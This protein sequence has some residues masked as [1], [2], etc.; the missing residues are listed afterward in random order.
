M[1][2]KTFIDLRKNL[3]LVA[4]KERVYRSCEHTSCHSCTL[5]FSV[6]RVLQQHLSDSTAGRFTS[7]NAAVHTWRPATTHLPA[8]VRALV[9]LQ[10]LES[11]KALPET[12]PINYSVVTVINSSTEQNPSSEANSSS[13]I[14]EIPDIIWKLEV[15]NHTHNSPVT[16]PSP[17]PNQSRPQPFILFLYE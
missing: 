12:V 8:S 4:H 7:P 6:R 15:H 1:L 13:A 5:L 10:L 3:G 16:C 9:A 17:D 14:Q 2:V 11:R